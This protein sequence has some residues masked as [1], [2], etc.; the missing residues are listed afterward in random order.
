MATEHI[1]FG[2]ESA[3]VSAVIITQKVPESLLDEVPLDTATGAAIRNL[4]QD[5]GGAGS[6]LMEPQPSFP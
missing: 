5:S 1:N 2:S 4:W 3:K 6:R